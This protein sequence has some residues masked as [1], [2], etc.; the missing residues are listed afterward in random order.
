M[1]MSAPYRDLYHIM[2]HTYGSWLSGDPRG[3]HTRHHRQ[4]CEGDYKNPPPVGK[5][6]WL[7]E[8]SKQLMKRDP[9]YLTRQ[10]RE[11]ALQALV[12]SLVERHIDVR[13]AALD[14]IHLHLL[15]RFVDRNPRHWMGIAKK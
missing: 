9:V 15:A 6:D 2:D 3:F 11:I 4:H 14:R 10:Q 7:Y 13:I 12:T 1:V 5:F 8:R